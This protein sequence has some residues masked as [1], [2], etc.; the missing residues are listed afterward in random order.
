MG[1]TLARMALRAFE[2]DGTRKRVIGVSRFR[3]GSLEAQLRAEG[4]ITIKGD[5]LD[6]GFLRSL[7]NVANVVAMPGMKFGAT[8]DASSTWATNVYLA[9]LI[10]QRWKSSRIVAFSTGNVYPLTPVER[11]GSLESEEPSPLGEYAMTALGRERIYE[12]F[13]RR[14]GT[15]VALLRLNYANELR[16]G[17]LVDL[18]QKV[19]SGAAIDLAM[20]HFNVLWQGDA[21]AM[22]LRALGLVAAPPFIINLAGPETLSV[23]RVCEELGT[24]LGRHLHFV[25]A[26]AADALLSNSSLSREHFGTPQVDAERMIRWVAD[27]VGRGGATL[28][29]PT[30]F[31][32]RDGRY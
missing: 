15:R 3:Q 23:R 18:A 22:A 11:G 32:T 26:E 14:F 24:R 12:H 28:G 29:K 16:Y 8:G 17:V 21:S 25:G 20:G 19:W 4:I 9:G 6:E 2:A 7:P 5:L 27:W 13:S 1:P 30:H 31:E 10:C